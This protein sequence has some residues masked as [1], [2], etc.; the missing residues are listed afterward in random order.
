MKIKEV[1]GRSTERTPL[2]T[3][4]SPK[5]IN[6]NCRVI[7][8]SEKKVKKLKVAEVFTNF[9]KKVFQVTL[10]NETQH[11]VAYTDKELENTL[12]YDSFDAGG[13]KMVKETNNQ[14]VL[15]SVINS[16]AFLMR[17]DKNLENIVD[18][19]SSHFL[20]DEIMKKRAKEYLKEHRDKVIGVKGGVDKGWHQ[21]DLRNI[22]RADCNEILSKFNL[23]IRF[24][25]NLSRV[26]SKNCKFLKSHPDRRNK[27]YI[28]MG[29]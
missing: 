6:K 11:T 15:A 25:K 20:N 9:Q 22:I 26:L 10:T 7:K 14:C 12:G 27:A 4:M 8:G 18:K 13:L 17:S 5:N 16:V 28:L 21:Y 23:S 3:K 29:Y 19:L 2:N 24:S 1:K